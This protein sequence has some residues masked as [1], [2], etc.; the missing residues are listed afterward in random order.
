VAVKAIPLQRLVLETDAPY[1]FPKNVRPRMKNN[2]PCCLPHVGKKVAELT[3]QALETIAS[4]SYQNA[5]NAF[6]IKY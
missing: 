4:Q 3:Q 2:E 1:L 5:L 6:R